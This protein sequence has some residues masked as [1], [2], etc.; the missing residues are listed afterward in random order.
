MTRSRASIRALLLEDV[1]ADAELLVRELRK[2]DPDIAVHCVAGQAEFER[3][4]QDFVPNVVISDHNLPHFSGRDALALVLRTAPAVPFIL[5]TG[6]LS[7][8]TAVEYMKAGAADYLLKDRVT[9]LGPAVLAALEQC[10]IRDQQLRARL[11]AEEALRTQR[12]FL[13]AVVDLSPSLIFVK[14]WD[15]RFVLVNRAA[16]EMA[17]CVPFSVGAIPRSLAHAPL[18]PRPPRACSSVWQPEDSRSRSPGDGAT[19]APPIR[20]LRARPGAVPGGKALGAPVRRRAGRIW[21]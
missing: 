18:A 1:P 20:A 15:G 3:A 12:E 9:R 4:L 21:H 13:R 11:E 2:A 7:E 5:V 16:A 14:D 6:S 17:L 10:R 8:E 19:R